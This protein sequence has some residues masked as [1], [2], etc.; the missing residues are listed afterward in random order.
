M[1]GQNAASS[2]YLVHPTQDGNS[3]GAT[4]TDGDHSDPFQGIFESNTGYVDEMYARYSNNPQSVTPEWRAYF[5]G[6]K[7]GFAACM[8]AFAGGAISGTSTNQS[9]NTEVAVYQLTRAFQEFGHLSANLDPLG[10][11]HPLDNPLLRPETHGLTASDLGS[12]T[13]MGIHF[14]WAPTTVAEYLAKMRGLFCGAVGIECE[15]LT[16]LEERTWIDQRISRLLAKPEA[17]TRKAMLHELA[18]ADAFEKTLATKYLGQKRFSAE[19]ADAQVMALESVMDHAASLGVKAVCMGKAHRGRLNVL[20]N[21]IGKPL[22]K[23]F[24]EFDGRKGPTTKGDGD[25]KYHCGWETQ[26]TTRSGHS[27]SVSLSFNPSHLEFVDPVVLGEC[28][29]VSDMLFNSDRQKVLPVLMHGDAAFAGQGIV[30][31]TMQ[32]MGIKGQRVGGCVHL[33]IN[34]QVGFTTNPSDS[35]STRYCSDLGKTFGA[36][37]FHVNADALD[38]LHQVMCLAAE[39]RQTFGKDVIVDMVCFRRHGHN[40]TDEPTFTQPAMY[41][42]VKAKKAPFEEF[43]AK[44]SAEDGQLYSADEFAQA[45]QGLR[46]DMAAIFDDSQK[47]PDVIDIFPP[48]RKTPGHILAGINDMLAPTATAVAA[49]TLVSLG[50]KALEVPSGFTPNSKLDRIVLAE[51][52]DMLAG[53]KPMDWGMGEFLAYASLLSEG[54]SIRLCGQDAGRGTFSHRHAVLVDNETEVRWLGL[55]QVATPGSRIEIIDSFLSEAA[56]MG[57]EYGYSCRNHNALTI[58]EGQFGDFCNGAQVIIDQFLVSG[59]SKWCQSQGLVL[60]LPHGYEGQGPEHSSGRLE[61]FLQLAAE[62]NIQVCLLTN[63]AQLF[64]ALRR[65]VK[66]NF[67]KPLVIMTPKSFLRSPKASTDLQAL[68]QGQFEEILGDPRDLD[69][70]QVERLVLCAG[71]VALDAFAHA[72]NTENTQRLSTNRTAIIRLEQV[73]PLHAEKLRAALSMYPKAKQVFWVQEEPQNMGAYHMVR[74]ELED[75][76]KHSKLKTGLRYI[77]R[78]RRASPAVGSPKTH[79]KEFAALMDAIFQASESTLIENG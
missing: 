43:A 8:E 68:A 5:A 14:G 24:A 16:T 67:R 3:S 76:L 61:R 11:A 9:L 2:L 56:A 37:I 29:A 21:V 47:N 77:G 10:L 79:A 63:A 60:Y 32:M 57:F 45:Y 19:G 39:Y 1:N 54:H 65:Q 73:Y 25:V 38:E 52:R 75:V 72:E 59:E 71:K 31:E 49:E 69:P 55:S 50:Q 46:D 40:E 23:L 4:Q 44:L 35:R 6:F 22:K 74:D 7:G 13:A 26:R 41:R 70:A 30:Y 62:G 36:P 17:Q 18:K 28:R 12:M 15:H 33:L 34:N 51:R 58:W 27:L 20:V 53:A 78:S 64:H 42:A 66:R 48:S